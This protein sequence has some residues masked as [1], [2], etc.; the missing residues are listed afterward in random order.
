MNKFFSNKRNFFLFSQINNNK[1]NCDMEPLF[2]SKFMF[3]KNALTKLTCLKKL[4]LKQKKLFYVLN[5]SPNN[6]FKTQKNKI[7]LN[8]KNLNSFLRHFFID[9][10][11]ILED[12]A[13]LNFF[14]FYKLKFSFFK[15]KQVIL[16]DFFFILKKLKTF[17][18]NFIT[19][20]KKIYYYNYFFLK[21]TNFNDEFICKI[22]KP[23]FLCTALAPSSLTPATLGLEELGSFAQIK[24]RQSR[25]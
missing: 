10:E 2:L 21:I 20:R 4:Y 9:P 24:P 1:L 6:I 22:I 13:T 18:K 5:I 23:N 3:P 16:K 25:A 19:K 7:F 8:S 15:Q 11:I 12:T 17:K 14:Y